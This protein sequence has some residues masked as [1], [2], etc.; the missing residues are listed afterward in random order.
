MKVLLIGKFP[1][2]QG[3]VS[4]QTYWLAHELAKRGHQVSVV[5][6][7]REVEP[8]YRLYMQSEDWIRC[9]DSLENNLRVYWTAPLDASQWHIP[10][11][12]PSVTKLVSL[13]L[14]AAQENGA[15]VIFSSYLEPYGVAGYLLAQQLGIPHVIKTAGSDVG[16]LWTHPQYK[17][18]YDQIFRRAAAIWTAGPV[19]KTLIEEYGLEPSSIHVGGVLAAPSDLFRPDG[20]A[21]DLTSL[22]DTLKQDTDR[23]GPSVFGVPRSDV[24]YFG[25]YGKIAA[26]KGIYDLVKAVG[27]IRDSGS[28]AGL[29]LMGSAYER[30]VAKFHAA[31][32]D[33]GLEDRVLHIPFL[34]HWYVPQFIRRCFAVCCLERDFPIDLHSP[35]LALEVMLCG[36]CLVG[37]AEVLRKMPQAERLIDGYNCVAIENVTDTEALSG[38][39]SAMVSQP[40]L[41]ASVKNK[42]YEYAVSVAASYD[43]G[44]ALERILLKALQTEKAKPAASTGE[45]SPSWV[46]LIQLIRERVEKPEHEI[47]SPDLSPIDYKLWA[48][49]FLAN[50]R[51]EEISQTEI[52]PHQHILRMC[53]ILSDLSPMQGRPTDE[54]FSK[55]IY[56]LRTENWAASEDDLSNLASFDVK[57]IGRIVIEKFEVEVG[58]LLASVQSGNLPKMLERAETYL[59]IQSDKEQSRVF[60]VD[61]TSAE[62]LAKV[63]DQS[64]ANGGDT[65]LLKAKNGREADLLYSNSLKMLLEIGLISLS[66]PRISN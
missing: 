19:R 24:H 52:W 12:N 32:S 28:M 27:K 42:A 40:E 36:G 43:D 29:L 14:Q 20:D 9:E 47:A 60:V 7:A 35:V 18:F 51:D 2:I 1:P 3:G 46:R 48:R 59:V 5:T 64:I 56:R 13:G 4:T 45:S 17:P 23:R 30:Q 66:S 11:D 8:A 25:M 26:N 49:E 54:R 55:L 37:S 58:Q 57:A 6:N 16:R 50:A 44:A 34:P 21:L 15:D 41:A 31:L 10:F 39:L 65:E 38:R 62:I 61:R 33:A 53:L 63:A 22:V